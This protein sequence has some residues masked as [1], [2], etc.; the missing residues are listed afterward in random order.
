MDP[1]LPSLYCK[2]DSLVGYYVVWDSMLMDQVVLDEAL[3][4]GKTNSYL[5]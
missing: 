3:R 5:K 2:M 4:D 1:L